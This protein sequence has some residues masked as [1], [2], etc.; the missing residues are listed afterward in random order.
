MVRTPLLLSCALLSSLFACGVPDA[1]GG[2]DPIHGSPGDDDQGDDDA[3]PSP[4]DDTTPPSDDDQSP[5]VL[6][7]SPSP[8]LLGEGEVRTLAFTADG[9]SLDPTTASLSSA[10]AGVASVDEEGN[11]TG[12]GKGLTSLTVSYQGAQV[13]VPVEVALLEARGVWVTRWTIASLSESGV[14]SLIDDLADAGFNQVFFQIRGNFD[15]LYESALEP[16]SSVLDG[17]GVDPGW[18]PLAVGVDQAHARGIELHAYLNTFPFWTGSSPPG[19]SSPVHPYNAHPDW[20]VADEDGDPM[21]LNSSYVFASPGNPAVRAWV[22]GV[23]EDIASR[24]EVDGIHLD[25]IRYPEEAYSH[26]DASLEAYQDAQVTDPGLSWVQFQRDNITGTVGEVSNRVWGVD[27]SMKVTCA[28]WGIYHN[29]FGWSGISQGLDDYYQDSGA[30][31]SQ[32]VA[33]AILPMIYWPLTSP[34]GE[35]LDWK[36]LAQDHQG[37]AEAAGRHQY[38]GISGDYDSFQEIADEI[39]VAR[40]IGAA[41]T[42]IFDYSYLEDRG[43]LDDLASGPFAEEARVPPMPWKGE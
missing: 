28:V 18:D 32:G 24:Y 5:P 37:R 21:A 11:V 22:A 27:P 23:A 8:L 15:A 42:V 25:Y 33:D 20:L 17:L 14:R 30:F 7:A 10:D 34:S 43:F 31:L 16:W 3:T 19:A 38:A 9:A 41:G 13:E 1:G 29:S 40:E 4:D 12:I 36:T 35:Y 6:L 2:D 39:Q 26:D